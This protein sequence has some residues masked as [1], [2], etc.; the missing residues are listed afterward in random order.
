[1]NKKG[2]AAVGAIIVLQTVILTL[3]VYKTQQD[4]TLKKNGQRIWCKMQNKGANFCD[5]LYK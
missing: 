5:A 2:M 1:M 4:G 3:V